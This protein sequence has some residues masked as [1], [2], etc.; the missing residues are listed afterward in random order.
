[1]KLWKKF[2]SQPAPHP[3]L[4]FKSTAWSEPA[5]SHTLAT[6]HMKTVSY[7]SK[8]VRGSKYSHKSIWHYFASFHLFSNTVLSFYSLGKLMKLI[9]GSLNNNTVGNFNAFI[10]TRRKTWRKDTAVKDYPMNWHLFVT[11]LK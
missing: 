5:L 8:Y 6:L 1:M 10:I 9:F 4:S 2:T 11:D 7:G 3:T